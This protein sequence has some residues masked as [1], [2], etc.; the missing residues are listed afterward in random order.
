M[1]PRPVDLFAGRDLHDV[2]VEAHERSAQRRKKPVTPGLGAG[3]LT[4]GPEPPSA[5]DLTDVVDSNAQPA[6]VVVAIS[7]SDAPVIN[8]IGSPSLVSASINGTTNTDTV[9]RSPAAS[10][11]TSLVDDLAK[12]VAIDTEAQSQAGQDVDVQLPKFKHVPGVGMVP[13]TPTTPEA[14]SGED[15][16][17]TDAVIDSEAPKSDAL[18]DVKTNSDAPTA[19]AVDSDYASAASSPRSDAGKVLLST[20]AGGAEPNGRSEGG[21]ALLQVNVVR[22]HYLPLFAALQ[23]VLSMADHRHWIPFFLLLVLRY[24]DQVGTNI[25]FG[26][27]SPRNGAIPLVG[28]GG[29]GKK[30][31]SAAESHVVHDGIHCDGGECGVRSSFTTGFICPFGGR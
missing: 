29:Q 4:R 5:S 18:Q 9:E 24:Q 13:E 27:G 23:F 26:S 15:G 17:G 22:H 14:T 16:A 25:A 30:P 12:K 20:A 8:G 28:G 11:V 7:D 31:S 19:P 3:S 10:T 6:S 2:E 1:L 21:I